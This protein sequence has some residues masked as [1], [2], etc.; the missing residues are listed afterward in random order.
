[1]ASRPVVAILMI[2][3]YDDLMKA[4]ADTARSAVLAQIDE[5]LSTWAA[6]SGGPLL[7]TERDHYLFIFEQQHYEHFAEDRFSVLD[8]IRDIKVGEGVHPTLSIGVG[9]D[10]DTMAE[11]YKNANLSVEMALSRGGCLLYTSRCV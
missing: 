9:K 4:C 1:M 8:A 10:A 11:L 7:K 2:D 3:N 6:C 5:K